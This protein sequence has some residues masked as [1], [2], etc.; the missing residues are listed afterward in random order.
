V[1]GPHPPD[2]CIDSN[3]LTYVVEAMWRIEEPTDAQAPEKVALLRAFLY[4]P[5]TLWT[6]PTVERE[7]E[8]MRDEERKARHRALVSVLFGVRQIQRPG[9]VERRARDLQ[10]WHSDL[11]D[12]LVVAEAE[13][14]EC[15]VLLSFDKRLVT[16]LAAHTRLKLATP[17][18]FWSALAIPRGAKPRT[19]PDATNPLAAQTWWRW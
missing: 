15:N 18:E 9:A 19:V 6:V 17:S 5:G 1:T 14:V 4:L 16:R 7:A 8:A 12:C 2:I 10:A 3:C 13:D 11:N